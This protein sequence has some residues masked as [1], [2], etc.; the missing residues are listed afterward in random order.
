YA[1]DVIGP[2]V[3]VVLVCAEG[4]ELEAKVRLARI[5]FD[6]VLGRLDDPSHAFLARPEV[7]ERSSRLTAG[8]LARRLHEVPDLVLL[9]VR[10]PGEVAATGTIDGALRVPLPR[11]GAE[12]DNLDPNRPT[13]A[14]CAGGYR[15]SIAASVLRAAGFADVS[16]LL[17]GYGAWA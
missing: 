3:P 9:D 10:N 2:S 17:G 6:A 15:S 1:G 7:V 11:L 14:Y 12:V 4:T 8:E 16:D 13:V 5:G